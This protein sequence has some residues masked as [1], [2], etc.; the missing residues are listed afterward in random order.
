MPHCILEYTDNVLD[1]PNWRELLLEIHEALVAS[2]LFQRAD[3]KSRVVCHSLYVIGDGDPKRAFVT[4]NL[5]ILSGRTDEQ[6]TSLSQ[7][8]LTIL[9]RT[10]PKTLH[11]GKCSFTVQVSELHRASYQRIRTED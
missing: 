7:A 10:F 3:I 4:L 5:Q 8:C 9:Q 1:Q 2:G 11:Q 6:K